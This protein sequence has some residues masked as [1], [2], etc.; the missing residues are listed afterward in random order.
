MQV[1]ELILGFGNLLYFKSFKIKEMGFQFHADILVF[2]FKTW[3]DDQI[4][5]TKQFKYTF[6]KLEKKLT[7]YV[8]VETRTVEEKNNAQKKR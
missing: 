3:Q 8:T 5:D 7:C 2:L 1:I 6:S 4:W